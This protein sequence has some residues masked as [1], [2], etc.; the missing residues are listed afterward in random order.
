MCG[1]V[2]E[3]NFL[4]KPINNGILQTFDNQRHRGTEGFGLFDGQE[5][6]M[7]HA[8]KE[9][10]I[11]KWLVK[12]DSNLILFHHRNPTSTINVKRASH[13]FSTKDYF[14]K[15]QYILVHNGHIS[16]SKDLYKE[17][18]EKGITYKS[19]LDDGTFNDSESLLW[20]LSLYLEGKQDKL[21]VTG[22]IAFVCLKLVNKKL[23]NMYFGRNS[24]PLNLLRTK[25]GLSLSSEGE[26]E[27]IESNMLYTYGYKSNYLTSKKLEIPQWRTVEHN[28]ADSD[29]G[30]RYG[31]YTPIKYIPAT[32]EDDD[33]YVKNNQCY[34]SYPD[35]FEDE[36]EFQRYN[37]V[38]T[39]KDV[40]DTL[41]DYLIRAKGVFETAYWLAETDYC[42]TMELDFMDCDDIQK[43]ILLE[44]VLEA[45]EIHPEYT[46]ET[47]VSKEW[48]AI[49][50]T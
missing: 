1:I 17:H 18:L 27:A 2:Y 11:L 42:D 7:V 46:S 29:W 33:D 41:F 4:G 45:I 16:N 23:V 19:L 28:S 34:T 31:T 12:Y 8:T 10:N 22:G 49:W 47:A 5:T 40:Q 21:T 20:D 3:H 24:N 30:F 36:L 26:G 50:A 14:G 35:D 48:R 43:S 6:H 15:T 38:P 44:H 37:Y 9:D 32:Y 13:P 25:D 39:D